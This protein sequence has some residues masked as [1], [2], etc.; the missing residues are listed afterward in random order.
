MYISSSNDCLVA[1]LDV[2]LLAVGQVE[3]LGLE[4]GEI[5]VVE[6]VRGRVGLLQEWVLE[7]GEIGVEEVVMGQV[8]QLEVVVDQLR[9]GLEDLQGCVE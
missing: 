3:E 6:V 4:V 8:D 7:V 2:A 1:L 5:G 9:V